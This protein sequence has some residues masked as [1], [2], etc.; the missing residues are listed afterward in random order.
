MRKGAWSSAF[1]LP[2]DAGVFRDPPPMLPNKLHRVHLAGLAEYLAN[3]SGAQPP[4]WCL[5]DELY[6]EEPVFFGGR[7]AK[8]TTIR[9]TPAAFR[10]RLLFTGRALV[11]I[12]TML[13]A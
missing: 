13:P 12:F 9:E 6:L 4:P 3:L 8:E 10:N 1:V 11:K 5:D 7:A 2:I